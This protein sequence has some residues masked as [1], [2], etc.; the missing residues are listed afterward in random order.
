MSDRAQLVFNLPQLITAIAPQPEKYLIW[1]RGTGKSTIIG[2]EMKEVVHDMPR[3]LNVLVGETYL[4]ILTRTLPSTTAALERLGYYK[5]IHYVIGRRGPR[6]WKWNEPYQAPGDYT[7]SIHWYTGAVYALISQDRSGRGL[8]TDSGIGDEAALL[9]EEKLNLDVLAT[10]RGS[11]PRLMTKRKFM[12]KMFCSTHPLTPRGRWLYKM[13]Q[14][15]RNNPAEILYLLAS[16]EENRINLP[17]KWFRDQKRKMPSFLY[18]VEILNHKPSQIE[19]GFYPQLKELHFYNDFNYNY[20]D[21]LNYNVEK[22]SVISKGDNDCNPDQ[23]LEI[24]VDWGAAINCM[25]VCQELGDEFRFIK[26]FFV[27]SPD[28]LDNL[29]TD[30]FIP[31]YSQHRKRTV[32][33]WYD[34]NGNSRIANSDLTFFEQA[35]RLLRNAGWDVI[36]MSRGLDPPHQDKYLLWNVILSE[37]NRRMPRIRFNKSN[38]KEL[39]VSMQNAPVKDI[40]GIKKDKTSEGKKEIPQE[41]ATHFSDAA[42]IIVYGKYRSLMDENE[43]FIDVVYSS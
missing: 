12:N 28:I 43:T 7:H 35:E 17:D 21:S 30:E 27:K 29:F 41:E 22:S 3:S 15:A 38:C 24:S 9:D 19:D 25:V 34:R 36:P 31:Y 4:Q 37:T 42:D 23:E 26:N 6:S 2:W 10:M 39:I 33:F 1:G 18:N 40:K 8:N 5:D 13:E 20:Y 14:E 32:R 11:D 16:A